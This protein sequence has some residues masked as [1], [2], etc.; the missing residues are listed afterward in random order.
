MTCLEC[1]EEQEWGGEQESYKTQTSGRAPG[2]HPCPPPAPSRVAFLLW[3][4]FSEARLLCLQDWSSIQG[5]NLFRFPE[6][7]ARQ[8]LPTL[9]YKQVAVSLPWSLS[10]YLPVLS[11]GDPKAT[12]KGRGS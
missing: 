2:F 11:S 4:P 10:L 8:F 3:L 12:S 7:G 1:E 6:G 9:K 5:H